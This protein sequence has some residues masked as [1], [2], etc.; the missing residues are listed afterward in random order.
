MTA[1]LL[2][3]RPRNSCRVGGFQ[4]AAR[5]FR[6]ERIGRPG[7]SRKR[8]PLCQTRSAPTTFGPTNALSVAR[9]GTEGA[10]A[11]TA[12]ARQPQGRRP[13]GGAQTGTAGAPRGNLKFR[14][15]F[16]IND[17][18]ESGNAGS[19]T[20]NV[21]ESLSAKPADWVPARSRRSRSD[22]RWTDVKRELSPG[23]GCS[24]RGAKIPDPRCPGPH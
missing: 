10:A 14:S 3:R 17:V 7:F 1:A 19:E 4:G 21:E 5:C 16:A 12:G 2:E 8:E 22:S 13:L 15:G 11:R 6:G 23:S 9:R 24:E 18:G 20:A